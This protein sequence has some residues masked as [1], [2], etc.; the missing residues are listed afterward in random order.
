MFQNHLKNPVCFTKFV[1]GQ[2]K[3][4]SIKINGWSISNLYKGK[5]KKF[6]LLKANSYKCKPCKKISRQILLYFSNACLVYQRLVQMRYFSAKL[7]SFL[8]LLLIKP[9]FQK[10]NSEIWI[11]LCSHSHL[12]VTWKCTVELF[13]H[14][15][16][17]SV[18]AVG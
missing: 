12:L 1:I 9:Q 5:L 8:L 3:N 2:L 7:K 17:K 15:L 6:A 4:Q 18:D 11:L 14:T 13:S 16:E 10:I